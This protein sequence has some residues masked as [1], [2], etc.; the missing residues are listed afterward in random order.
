MSRQP[1][2][3]AGQPA[4]PS[5]SKTLLSLLCLALAVEVSAQDAKAPAGRPS[6]PNVI[7]ILADDA[8]F[9]DLGF[10]GSREIRTPHIDRIAA[11]GIRFSDA[12]VT[13]PFCSPSR[14]GLLTGRYPQR[15]GYE[16]NLTHNPPPGVSPEILGLAIEERTIADLMK[17]A[18]Y[19]TIAIGKWHLGRLEHFHPNQRGFDHFYGFLGGAANYHPGQQK[20]ETQWIR[21]NAELVQPKEYLT[22]DFG[23]EAL[24]YIERFKSVPFFMYLA[25]NAVHAPMDVVEADLQRFSHVKDFQRQRLAAMT[26]AMDRAVGEVLAALEQHGLDRDTLVIFTNDNGGDRTGIGA[27]NAPLRGTKGTLLE[28]GIRVPLAMRWPARVKAGTRSSAIVSLMDVLPTA[29][30]AAGADLPDNLDGESL[31]GHVPGPKPRVRKQRSLFWRYDV[32]AA[33]REGRFKLLR[34]PDRPPQLYDLRR[35]IAEGRDLARRQ[36]ARVASLLKKIFAWEAGL[37]H[38]RWN[39]GTYWS[40]EDVRRY[41]DKHVARRK[42]RNRKRLREKYSQ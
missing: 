8:G 34:F 33:V 20:N 40:Q 38:A 11:E 27:N 35:D 1:R 29:L 31:L 6:K 13:T 5:G 16:Y 10:Q 30:D 25:F 14:A 24:A 9:H 23:R 39:T 22:G 4:E 36:P 7:V 21:R 15:F 2:R 12:Y 42:E 19:T 26:W 3:R 17:A 28:G 41:D 37:T 18:G 32:M